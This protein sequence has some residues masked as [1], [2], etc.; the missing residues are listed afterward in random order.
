LAFNA[1]GTQNVDEQ[2]KPVAPSTAELIFNIITGQTS[3]RG[4]NAKVIDSFLL[5][6]LANSGSNTF[7]NGL[8]GVERVKYNFLVRKQLGI[9]TD[10]KGNRFFVNGY[11]SEDATVYTQEGPRTEKRFSTQFTNLATLT[12]FE[13][14]RIVF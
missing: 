13:K 5:S 9:Y 4:S 7:T 8:E 3:V 1:D 10:D 12:D 11:Y 14:R 2:G 6:L